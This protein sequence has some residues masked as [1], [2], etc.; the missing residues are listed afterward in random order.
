MYLMVVCLIAFKLAA[1]VKEPAVT[2]WDKTIALLA[3]A[4]YVVSAFTLVGFLNIILH[5]GWLGDMESLAILLGLATVSSA[6]VAHIDLDSFIESSEQ[7]RL[8]DASRTKPSARL[9]NGPCGGMLYC[10]VFIPCVWCC[11]P[12][13][14]LLILLADMTETITVK[15]HW[16]RLI[17]M[18]SGLAASI[19]ASNILTA[20]TNAIADASGICSTKHCHHPWLFVGLQLGVAIVTTVVLV[21]FV[22]CVASQE[23]NEHPPPSAPLAQ[24]VAE[25]QYLLHHPP[26]Q[27]PDYNPL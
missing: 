25:D 22:T 15:E 18:V 20:V 24:D 4:M 26:P 2:L 14:P 19:E 17:A 13:V 7:Q 5:P 10:L 9:S 11:C 12:W 1:V 16:F 3:F 8:S 21:P 6:L 27:N 23:V